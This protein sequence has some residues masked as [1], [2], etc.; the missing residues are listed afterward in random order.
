MCCCVMAILGFA[1]LVIRQQP[2]KKG[3]PNSVGSLR[4]DC[5]MTTKKKD[6]CV[7]LNCLVVTACSSVLARKIAAANLSS[8]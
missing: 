1:F 7:T 3:S 4:V 8:L 2:D 5:G 6:Y